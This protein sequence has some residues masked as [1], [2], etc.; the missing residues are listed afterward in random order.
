LQY[1]SS[2][3]ISI[4]RNKEKEFSKGGI[5][6]PDSVKE[7]PLKGKIDEIGEKV[8]L[9]LKKG[10]IVIFNKWA[11][12]EISVNGKELLIMKESDILGKLK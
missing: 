12:N 2:I 6:I 5:I 3:K 1:Q 11:G 9:N 7:K 8:K 10:D 4:I